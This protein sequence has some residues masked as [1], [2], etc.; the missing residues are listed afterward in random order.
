[1]TCVI[2]RTRVRFG[3]KK[4]IAMLISLQYT[5]SGDQLHKDGNEM[6]TYLHIKCCFS[7]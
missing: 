6:A 2:C 7:I 5:I 4:Q 1:M 3:K